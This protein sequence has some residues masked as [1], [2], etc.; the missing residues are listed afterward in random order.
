MPCIVVLY[1]EGVIRNGLNVFYESKTKN[2]RWN[3][4]LDKLTS[5]SFEKMYQNT[6]AASHTAESGIVTMDG[7]HDPTER[8]NF[9][10]TGNLINELT[11][12]NTT[13]T[14]L[15]GFESIDTDNENFRFNTYW[16]SKDC[17]V[18]ELCRR[19][20][21]AVSLYYSWRKRFVL[22]GTFGLAKKAPVK[23]KKRTP[24]NNSPTSRTAELN[25][26]KKQYMGYYYLFSLK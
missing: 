13:H 21:I 23:M 20:N 10:I 6:Y 9:I 19:N 5:N 12:G 7:Y 18:S 15:A 11:I 25:A 17:S 3:G 14:I 4:K 8:D 1:D 22:A 26:I 24:I 2:R 16:T